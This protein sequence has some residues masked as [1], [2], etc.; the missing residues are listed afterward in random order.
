VLVKVTVV[1]FT[2]LLKVVPP[3]FPIVSVPTPDT[4]VPAIVAPET[5]PVVNVKSYVAPVTAPI[6]KSAALSLATVLIAAAAPK[7]IEPKVIGS[8][9]AVMVPFKVEALGAVAVKPPL[10]V[11]VPPLAPKAKVPVLLKVTAL[12]IVPV[13]ALSAKL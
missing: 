1:A 5:P 3:E 9:L 8:L 13:L 2:V 6:I 7:V 10:K 12:V 4:E 11:K